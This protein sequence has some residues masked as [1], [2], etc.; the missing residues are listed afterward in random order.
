LA[1]FIDCLADK[2]IQ[3]MGVCLMYRICTSCVEFGD[4]MS[5]KKLVSF[6][7]PDN[8]MDSLRQTADHDGT[9]VTELVCRLLWR[10]LQGKTAPRETVDDR[11]ASLEA[12]IQELR[13]DRA[14]VASAP[15]TPL[16]ALLT[17]SSIAQ[18]SSSEMRTRLTRLEQMMETLITQ[19]TVTQ[20]TVTQST[21]QHPAPAAYPHDSKAKAQ[22]YP[23]E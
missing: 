7:L 15:P 3:L 2:S 11:I 12:E 4:D 8:L 22:L 1:E 17:Q 19:N 20:G 14:P 9:S 5:N 23:D 21:N 10:G 6:R 18:D 16:Y 13:Q